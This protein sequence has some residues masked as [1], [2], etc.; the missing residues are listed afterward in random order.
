[1]V[2][3]GELAGRRRREPDVDHV[4]A[5]RLQRR[6]DDAVKQRA[7]HAAVAAD[8]DLLRAAFARRPRAE[9]GRVL[10]HD[11]RRQRLAHPSADAGH[12]NHQA[13]VRH[14]ISLELTES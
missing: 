10:C 13:V 12:S 2:L 1:M 9:R 5:D 3:D 8:H 7:R 4:A 14:S 6:Q 11:L